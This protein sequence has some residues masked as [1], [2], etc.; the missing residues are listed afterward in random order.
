MGWML[1]K[2]E[3]IREVRIRCGAQTAVLQPQ[4]F[5]K[6]ERQDVL[7]SFAKFGYEDPRC[8]FIAYVPDIMR[9]D[10]KLYIEAETQRF[11]I[12]YRN[13]AAPVRGGLNAMKKLL[14]AVDIRFAELGPAFDRVLGPAIE[15]INAEHLASRTGRQIVEYGIV[16]RQAKY[17]VLVPLYGRLDFVEYQMALFSGRVSNA[18]VEYVFVLDDPPRRRE[19]QHLFTAI[20]ER[21]RIPFRAVLLE[22]NLGFG[23]ANNAGMEYCH[24]EYLIYLNSDVFPGSLDWLEQLSARLEAD[25]ELGVV[26]PLL[27]YEDGAVQHRGMYFERLE[28]YADWYFCQHFDKG[29]RYS[30]PGGMEYFISI[31]GACMMLRRELAVLLGG[32]DEVYAIG[33][34]EDSDLCLKIQGMGLRCGI[35]NDVRLFHLER[36]SQI[37][38][39]LTWRANLTAYNAWQHDRRWAKQIDYK[40][41]HEFKVPV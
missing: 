40:Q 14:G 17:S 23:P 32:F 9:P 41:A 11:E 36:K 6:I 21:F 26:G 30:G 5:I 18:D 7:D 24:G 35:D 10:K 37:S 33:D 31:T 22:R 19:A 25:S 3:E 38:G 39:A 4:S 15:A 1:A 13:I 16:P 28:E 12:G 29:L 2:P 8:G 27:V 20:Y 34:F